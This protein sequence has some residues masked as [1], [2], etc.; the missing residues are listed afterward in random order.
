MA[1]KKERPVPQPCPVCG[2]Q[3]EISKIKPGRWMVVCADLCGCG[4]R[5]AGFGAYED[6]AVVNWNKEVQKYETARERH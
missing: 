3:A 6:D 5:G 4:F 2:R 1:R